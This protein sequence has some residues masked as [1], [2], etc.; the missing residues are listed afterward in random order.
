MPNKPNEKLQRARKQRN[1]TQRDLADKVGV[2]EQTVRSWERGIRFPSMVSRARLLEVFDLS[3]EDLGLSQD[4]GSPEGKELPG[5]HPVQSV[6]VPLLVGADE[7]RQRMLKRV[8]SRWIKGIFEYS[9]HRAVLI[10]LGLRDQPGTVEN[11]WRL[12][13]QEAELP[14]RPLP[15]GTRITQVYDDANGELL[16]LGEPGAGKTTLLLELTRDLLDRAEHDPIHPLP[17]VFNL[18][19]WAVKR[20]PL[21]RWL[22]EELNAKYQIPHKIGQAWVNAEQ[23]LLLLD[24]LDEVAQGQRAACIDAINSY[25]E[26]HPLVSIVICSREAEYQTQ[27]KQLALQHAVG[28]QPLTRQQI[29]E[30]LS[31]AGEALKAVQEVLRNDPG[32]QEVVTTPLMLSVLTLAYH[33]TSAEVIQVADSP[34]A[35]RSQV[36]TAYVQRML[37][38]RKT[39]TRYSQEQTWHWLTC[40][41]TQLREHSQIEFYVERMQPDWLPPG[42]PRQRFRHAMVLLIFGIQVFINAALFS[43]LRGGLKGGKF[44]V[45]VGLLGQLGAG[46]RNTLLG[47]MAPGLGGGLEGGGSL[48]IIMALITVIVILLVSDPLPT[49][50]LRAL[51]S[52]LYTAL[53]NGLIIG[54]SVGI[55]ASLVFGLVFG[56]RNGL[57]RG[58][59][60]GLYSGLLIG[61]MSGLIAGLRYE[62]ESS[63][64]RQHRSDQKN[65]RTPLG[66][67]LFDVC[68]FSLCAALAFSGVY[69]LLAG[70]ITQSV[71]IYGLVVGCFYGLAFGVGGGTDLLRG[72]GTAIEPAEAVSWSW[73]SVRQQLAGN[74]RKG[75]LVGGT[76]MVPVG[77]I[78][79][80]MSGLFYGARYGLRYGL[81]FGIIVGIVGGVASILTGAL[82]S[83]WSSNV[84]AEHQLVRPN[85]GIRRS[86]KNA[87]FAACLFGSV[88]GLASGLVCGFAFGVVGE[89]VGWP[90]LGVGF[91]IVCGIIFA[92]EF[93]TIHGGVAYLEHYVLRW[94]LWRAG[95]MAWKYVG[96][97]DAAAERILLSKVGGG[98]MFSHHLLLD[99]FAAHETYDKSAK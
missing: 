97:L 2:E 35:Q 4:S 22:V 27:A 86:I 51:G 63:L 73:S 39:E 33:G 56:V 7:N 10:V 21:G 78:I 45:S 61:V 83:G 68:I 75:L 54:G 65:A 25:H 55:F 52:G 29:E 85:E 34:E 18:S 5:Q 88:G 66:A 38:R 19:S 15:A 96:F 82:N 57:I 28:I 40:L 23:L 42:Q 64:E 31:S 80:L 16:I 37:S 20:Q 26:E 46:P 17:V 6:P 70:G 74:I 93:L 67:R 1:W 43:W 89:L 90:I 84:L 11:P 50:S 87:V 76:V 9:L 71:V 72:L 13:M 81:I 95:S 92:L 60:A 79:G 49:L 98:Y 53:R 91:G 59:G 12:V 99:F 58:L 8:R 94:Y 24:G 44:G 62:R 30:Y 3:P 77:V 69:A 41:A 47:W 14:P 32:L 48:G 36:F